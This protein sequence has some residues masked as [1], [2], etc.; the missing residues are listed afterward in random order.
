ML[1]HFIKQSGLNFIR[2]YRFH[3]VRR[4]RFDFAFPDHKIAVEVEGG[5][6][7]RG[8][9]VRGKHYRSDCEKYL[10]AAILGW[11][12]LRFTSD[13][14]RDNPLWPIESVYKIIGRNKNNGKNMY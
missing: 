9:H 8:A 10:E 14:L 7:V 5:T 12:V 13:M 11:T 3:P 1:E 6:W 4:W 2:E